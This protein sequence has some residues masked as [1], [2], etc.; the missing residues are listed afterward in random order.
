MKDVDFDLY[1]KKKKEFNLMTRNYLVNKINQ[2]KKEVDK[3][4]KPGKENNILR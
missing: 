4:A 1:K 3:N 2:C